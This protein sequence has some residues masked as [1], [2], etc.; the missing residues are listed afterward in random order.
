[1][2]AESSHILYICLKYTQSTYKV[3]NIQKYIDKRGSIAHIRVLEA[4][5]HCLQ[6]MWFI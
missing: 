5:F 4:I 1:M 3:L 2:G 6:N